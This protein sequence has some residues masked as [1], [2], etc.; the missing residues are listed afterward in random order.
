MTQHG[1]AWRLEHSVDVDVPCT[2]AW[3]YMSNI[4]NWDDPPAT[5]EVDGPFTDGARGTT[6]MPDQPAMSWT[7]RDVHPERGYT[8]VGGEL[9]DRARMIVRWQFAPIS[10]T[11]ARLTQRMELTGENAAAYV[12]PI[13]AAFGPNIQP[14]MQRIAGL[15][16]LA[17]NKQ[18]RSAIG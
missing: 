12:E 5:F 7:L 16:V 3:A 17:F 14:G 9:L 15:M 6:C 18:S 11:K 8:I 2:F 4:S 13:A 1:L 10:A